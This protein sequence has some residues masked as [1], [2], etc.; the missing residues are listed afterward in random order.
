MPGVP[1][2][3]NHAA[4]TVNEVKNVQRLDFTQQLRDMLAWSQQEGYTFV[5][6]VR[7]NAQLSRNLLAAEEAGLLRIVRVDFP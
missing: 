2:G 7:R 3:I 6:Y 5:L 4:Q 1:D